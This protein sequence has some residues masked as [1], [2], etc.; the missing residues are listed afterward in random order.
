[1]S[2]KNMVTLNNSTHNKHSLSENIHLRTYS[3]EDNFIDLSSTFIDLKVVVRKK[4]D[5]QTPTV[6]DALSE[7]RYILHNLFTQTCLYINGMLVRTSLNW[8]V[9]VQYH[10]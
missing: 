3:L 6:A 10:V 5:N 7:E 1:M 4:S 9:R 8:L 2:V